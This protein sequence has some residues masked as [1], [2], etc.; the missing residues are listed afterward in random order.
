MGPIASFRGWASWLGALLLVVAAVASTPRV[1]AQQQL[2][3]GSPV[4]ERYWEMYLSVREFYADAFGF[5]MDS[6]VIPLT[7]QYQPGDEPSASLPARF[8]A[9]GPGDV[10]VFVERVSHDDAL[11][12]AD[13]SHDLELLQL[14][15]DHDPRIGAGLFIVES[16]DRSWVVTALTATSTLDARPGRRTAAVYPLY[17]HRDVQADKVRRQEPRTWTVED[18]QRLV[19][20]PVDIIGNDVGPGDPPDD[21]EPEPGPPDDE[22]PTPCERCLIE[23]QDELDAIES[24]AFDAIIAL[25]DR[26]VAEI[27]QAD[28]AYQ[29]RMQELAGPDWEVI[30][31]T[32]V[33]AGVGAAALASN[34]LGWATLIAGGGGVLSGGFGAAGAE[35]LISDPRAAQAAFNTFQSRLNA[36]ADDVNDELQ[37]INQKAQEDRDL[38]RRLFEICCEIRDCCEELGCGCAPGNGGGTTTK[39]PLA[40][41]VDEEPER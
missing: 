34:P 39:E 2:T 1:Y 5:P 41:P 14:I 36:I 37:R 13:H 32:A 7:G 29:A 24:E 15:R 26:A 21:P 10:A 31:A 33:F 35:W 3:E 40:G 17:W 30:A 8:S 27:Q 6:Q 20:L 19:G 11:V 22:D 4:L 38:A 9:L 28:D 25:L 23:Y 12:R 18:V 16:G